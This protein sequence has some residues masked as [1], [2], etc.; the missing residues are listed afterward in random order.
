MGREPSGTVEIKQF[1]H[2]S[3][4]QDDY[5]PGNEIVA[6]N[7]IFRLCEKLGVKTKTVGQPPCEADKQKVIDPE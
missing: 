2:R 6:Q 3:P 4:N 7:V 1:K 5:D